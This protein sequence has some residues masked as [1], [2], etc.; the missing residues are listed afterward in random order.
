VPGPLRIPLQASSVS[1]SLRAALPPVLVSDGRFWLQGVM[2]G[3]YRFSVP[4]RGLR[5][6]IGRWWLKS[7]QVNGREMLDSEL[8]LRQNSDDAVIVFSDRAS[9]LAGTVH[10]ADG[11][12]AAGRHVVVFGAERSAW[13]H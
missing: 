10:E 11:S 2:P 8:D 5:A 7:V 4:P 12:P 9:A 1:T 3:A 6:P 13:F